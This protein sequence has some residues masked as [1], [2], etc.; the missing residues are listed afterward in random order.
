MT[1]TYETLEVA[2]Q[3]SI[4]TTKKNSSVCQEFLRYAGYLTNRGLICNTFGNIAIRVPDP[5]FTDGVLYTKHRGISLEECTEAEIVVT[6]I[7]SNKL[8][9][10]SV[11]PSNGHQMSREIM[12]LRPDIN[13]II[14]TH[15][16]KICAYFAVI[17]NDDEVFRYIGNDTPL[18]LGSPP[19]I[20]PRHINLEVESN[21]IKDY[22]SG[23]SCLVMPN[24][25][26]VTMGRTLSEAYHRHT[27]FIAEIERLCL[28]KL[29]G[30]RNKYPFIPDEEIEVM[31]KVA[32]KVIYGELTNLK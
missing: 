27:S 6:A 16:D 23:T 13:A 8:L 11:P 14:H 4:F 9:M 31:Y 10:G 5:S 18:V 25:G 12:K 20:L 19:K 2:W 1:K 22:V 24:H 26:F 17:D 29:L 28:V 3:T 15:A 21:L 32:D 30:E 7:E